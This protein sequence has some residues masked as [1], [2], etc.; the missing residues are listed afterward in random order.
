VVGGGIFL[1]SSVC[2][3]FFTS[4]FCFGSETPDQP[5]S[6]FALATFS[7][8]VGGAIGLADFLIVVGAATTSLSP[9]TFV[10]VPDLTATPASK[11]VCCS[12]FRRWIG[13]LERVL[14]V[15]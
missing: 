5:S 4:S 3:F 14:S 2:I 9:S 15:L 1:L 10:S 13:R 12:T 7:F 11:L 6:T 8:T